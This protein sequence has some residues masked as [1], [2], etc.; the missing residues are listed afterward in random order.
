MDRVEDLRQA[1]DR[2]LLDQ[3]DHELQH[4][5][6]AHLYG[7]SLASSL[8][9]ARRGLNME[10]CAAAGILHDIYTCKTGEERDHALHGASIGTH[11]LRENGG[12]TDAEVE[13]VAAMIR[14]HSD[15]GRTDGPYEECL[16]DADV[17]Q[18]WLYEPQKKFDRDKKRRIETAMAE[19]GIAGEVMEEQ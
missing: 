6:F 15:K 4:D 12:F 16:K 10:L 8:L 7:V 19:L 5:G 2:V 14:V 9:A 11:M 3:K 18:R 1:V 17:L 13:T